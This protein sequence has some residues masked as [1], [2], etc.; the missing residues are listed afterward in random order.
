MHGAE[1]AAAEEV[2]KIYFT[3]ADSD[4]I[5]ITSQSDANNHFII[6]KTGSYVR[7]LQNTASYLDFL[8]DFKHSIII[9]MIQLLQKTVNDPML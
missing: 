7:L 9:P 8:I 6:T 3:D 4:A 2:T 1:N 5:T